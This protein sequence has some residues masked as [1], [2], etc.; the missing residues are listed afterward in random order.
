MKENKWEDCLLTG[1]TRK[2]TPDNQRANSLKETAKD[3]IDL[4]KEINE[5]NCNFV[6]EDY[7]TSLIE[8]LQAN[9]FTK[10]FNIL[11][12]ICLGYFL[13]EILKKERL[14]RIFN[15]LRYKRNS[16]TYY[17]NKMDFETAK[18]AIKNAKKILNELT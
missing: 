12:H 10:G 15:D 4:I 14:A 5:K 9:A 3:R 17:G 8:I 11:N 6:F 2:I 13:K 18:E 1:S 7:Y 16:L